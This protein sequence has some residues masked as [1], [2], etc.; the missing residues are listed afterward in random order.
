MDDRFFMLRELSIFD[1][2]LRQLNMK[3]YGMVS[4]LIRL[5]PCFLL[6][7]QF[8]G[9]VSIH[10]V[11]PGRFASVSNCN[12]VGPAP[13]SDEYCDLYDRREAV[14]RIAS[15]LNPTQLI[16]P[17]AIGWAAQCKD[18]SQSWM[19]S[20]YGRC[21]AVKGS[22]QGWIQAKKDEANA[23]PWPRFHPVPTKNV[24]EPQ[25]IERLDATGGPEV[26]GR[27]GKG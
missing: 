14:Q 1:C 3:G 6:F 21:A 4:K 2:Q 23:P 10:Q 24:F 20:Q 5:S 17:R 13:S 9:C 27:F 8:L 25:E 22:I 16:P 18:R 12:D 11:T 7:G 19:S 15:R 26:Y